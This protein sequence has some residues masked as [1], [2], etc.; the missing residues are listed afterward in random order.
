MERDKMGSRLIGSFKAKLDKGGRI[1]IPEK[2]RIA[3]EEEFGKSLFVTSLEDEF[4][5]VFPLP[6][7]EKMTETPDS[8]TRYPDP[9]IQ[10]FLR[11]AHM[12]GNGCEL[13]SKGRVL[14]VQALREKAGLQDEVEVIGLNNYLEIW[15]RTRLE[16]KIA[17]RPL[18]H[19]D[20]KNITKL[21]SD[22]KPE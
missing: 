20:F 15:D 5:Q 6:V 1:K 19:Q 11:K 18:T 17:Q 12:M 13:D 3:I 21:M 16:K 4:V 14:I 8:G 22:R 2:F 10:E 7:W 9:D